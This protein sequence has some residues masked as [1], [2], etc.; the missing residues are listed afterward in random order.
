VGNYWWTEEEDWGAWHKK[1]ST[2]RHKTDC[3]DVIYKSNSVGARDEQFQ[4]R[5][6]DKRR[7]LLLG[8]SFAEGYGVSKTDT[9]ETLIENETNTEIYN[10]GAAS[11]GPLQYWLLYEKL[12]KNYVHD[13]LL[14]FFLPQND[15]QDNDYSYWSDN[16]QTRLIFSKFER[17][18]PYYSRNEDL[19]GELVYRFFYPENAVKRKDLTDH[20]S[21]AIS[22][23]FDYFWFTNVLR[24]VSRIFLNGDS[25]AEIDPQFQSGYFDSSLEQQKAALFYL[26]KIIFESDKPVTLVS[27]PSKQDFL[28]LSEGASPTKE[29]WQTRF[30]NI[31]KASQGQFRFLDLAMARQLDQKSLFFE[32]DD[33]WSTKGNSWA[34]K[35]VSEQIRTSRR[36]NQ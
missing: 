27:I 11:L 29:W 34:A 14:I 30:K 19:S 5:K 36:D 3:F 4:T 24:T 18:R 23:L 6:G 20:P 8:D 16:G 35:I 25:D 1:S 9:A 31:E 15:F 26:E 10:F 21:F 2:A 17:Y 32:C 28:K 13:E 12:A 22:I 7:L 33:H